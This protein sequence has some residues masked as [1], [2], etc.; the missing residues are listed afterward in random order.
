M[1]ASAWLSKFHVAIEWTK[2]RLVCSHRPLLDLAFILL[3]GLGVVSEGGWTLSGSVSLESK[4]PATSRPHDGHVTTRAA[5]LVSVP[6]GT[7]AF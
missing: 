5:Q 6:Y 2:P 3:E 1:A 4:I 7:S